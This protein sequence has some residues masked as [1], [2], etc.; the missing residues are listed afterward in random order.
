MNDLTARPI[1]FDVNRS[2]A[3]MA[4]ALVT[5]INNASFGV[6]AT[7]A[8][9]QV[10]LS[11]DRTVDLNSGVSGLVKRFQNQ[12][13]SG[14]LLAV[15]SG[16]NAF[17]EGQTFEIVDANGASRTVELDSG[18]ILQVAPPKAFQIPAGGVADGAQ[19]QVDD[20][21]AG[22]RPAVTFE[23]TTNAA[24]SP[25]PVIPVPIAV[26]ATVDEVGE[27]VVTALKTAINTGRLVGLNAVHLGGGVI[28]LRGSTTAT[29]NPMASGL[30]PLNYDASAL[31]GETFVV[32]DGVN[33]VTYEF[34]SDGVFVDLNLDLSPDNRLIVITGSET[35][36][37]LAAL[38]TA[39]LTADTQGTGALLTGIEPLDLGN[40]RIHLGGTTSHSLDTSGS[41]NLTQN[42]TPGATSGNVAAR[43][44]PHASFTANDMADS[45]AAAINQ[46]T[47][48]T[49]VTTAISSGNRVQLRGD[50]FIHLDSDLAGLSVSLQARFDSGP[51]LTVSKPGAGFADGQTIHIRD[52]QNTT[53]SF[54]FERKATRAELNNTPVLVD[55]TATAISYTDDMSASEMAERIADAI[56]RAVIAQPAFRVRA[57]VVGA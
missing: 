11:G 9:N 27:A 20:D 34:D 23:F 8:G 40:G 19:F 48:P 46:L 33:T 50:K 49:F 41:T 10:L 17:V 25:S 31:D 21:G 38:I 56:N 44:V 30:L 52:D 22:P 37:E 55:P 4:Q 15:N 36:L 16:G 12:F 3:D 47:S 13:D 5:A 26:G 18:Y 2:Q 28:E 43:F 32:A 1:S 29:F 24:V 14:Q 54:E 53:Q 51:I 35:H 57:T 42:G 6:R 7:L 45:L 39:A